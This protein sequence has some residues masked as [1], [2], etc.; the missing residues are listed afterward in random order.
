MPS[1]S[2]APRGLFVQS[3]VTR[4]F[5][6]ISVKTMT[7]ENLALVTIEDKGPGVNPKIIDQIFDPFFTT[8]PTGIGMGLSISRALIEANGGQLWIDPQHSDGAKF[9]FTLPFAK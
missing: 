4:I 3:R 9:C 7:Q 5:T 1:Y 2:K 6:G 8:K